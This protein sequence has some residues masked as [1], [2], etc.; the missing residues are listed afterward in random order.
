MKK[1]KACLRRQGFT[2]IVIVLIVIAVLVVGGVAYYAE[3]S[4][5][6]ENDFTNQLTENDITQPTE[7]ENANIIDPNNPDMMIYTSDK[8]GIQFTYPKTITIG[9]GSPSNPIPTK[10]NLVSVTENGN[11]LIVS[12]GGSGTAYALIFHKNSNESF[13]QSILRQLVKPE[14]QNNPCYVKNFGNNHYEITFPNDPE[15]L[16]GGDWTSE[17]I[18]N[19]KLGEEKCGKIFNLRIVTTDPIS[20]GF[21]VAITGDHDPVFSS[22]TDIFEWWPKGIKFI[23]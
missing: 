17:E 8:L 10:T 19:M 13:E 18:V 14:Y 20:G 7:K 3:K 6:K 11:K 4:S 2:P 9:A 23:K 16:S 12:A 21:Y 5:K 22:N 1:N 15:G